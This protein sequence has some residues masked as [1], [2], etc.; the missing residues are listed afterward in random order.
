MHSDQF[1]PKSYLELIN[2]WIFSEGEQFPL[3]TRSLSRPSVHTMFG[4]SA[5]LVR[6]GRLHWIIRP[7]SS[8]PDTET[9]LDQQSRSSG[10]GTETP[11][12]HQSPLVWCRTRRLHWISRPARLV[13]ARESPARSRGSLVTTSAARRIEPRRPPGGRETATF[14]VMA[15]AL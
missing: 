7:R 6:T 1:K 5:R 13:R 10:P 12:D 8:G 15:S 2:K 11:L 14:D 3:S 9:P 4:R